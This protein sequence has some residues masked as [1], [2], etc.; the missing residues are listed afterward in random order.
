MKRCWLLETSVIWPA[1]KALLDTCHYDLKLSAKPNIQCCRIAEFFKGFN[2][3]KF[4]L[5]VVSKL[6]LSNAL[7]VLTSKDAMKFHLGYLI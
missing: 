1:F 5:R 2:T 6:V 3:V 4:A 7:N